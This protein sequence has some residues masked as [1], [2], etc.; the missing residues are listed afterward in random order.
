MPAL[1]TLPSGKVDRKSLP[2]PS[3]RAP[4]QERHIVSPTTPSE[5][6]L[7]SAWR[8]IFSPL[9][10]SIDDDFFLDL[11]GHSLRA[12]RMVSL[13]R[14]Q[15]ALAHVSMSSGPFTRPSQ[16]SAV[17]PRT[18]TSPVPAGPNLQPAQNRRKN[19]CPYSGSGDI[20]P[21][22]LRKRSG[23]IVPFSPCFRS[24]GSFP[25]WPMRF[26]RTRKSEQIY[27]R[28]HVSL[29]LFVAAIPV[30]LGIGIAVKWLVIG[31]LKPGE[32]PLW[33]AYYFR[34]W[35]VRRVLDT[36]PTHFL[37]GT[38]LIVFYYRLLG[39]RIGQNVLLRDDTIDAPDCVEIGDDASFSSGATLSCWKV[40]NGRLKIGRVRVGR[41]CYLG[42][43][44]SV[45]SGAILEDGAEV[46]DLSMVPPG[47]A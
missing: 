33:G 5:V 43:N 47:V 40:E 32:Y 31:R 36:V 41:G 46:Q 8:E 38:P 10:V 28:R 23:L 29:A 1:P 11:G 27:C 44:S 15:P 19:F 35:F 21:A 20:S 6:A 37:G 22:P 17:S 13:L 3:R 2:K 9:P 30:M 34:W 25:I 14:K 26:F 45:T 18:W 42:A 16:P 7:H 12:A 39:A 4:E 24:N